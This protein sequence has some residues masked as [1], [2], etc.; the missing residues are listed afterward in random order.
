MAET[1]LNQKM[2]RRH[3]PGARHGDEPSDSSSEKS[4]SHDEVDKS[5]LLQDV[6]RAA[7]GTHMRRQDSVKDTV[8]AGSW[9]NCPQARPG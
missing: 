5:R 6:V 9:R 7:R 8:D 3:P 1:K 4:P 2:V